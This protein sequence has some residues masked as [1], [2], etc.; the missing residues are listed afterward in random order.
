M[1]SLTGS[2]PVDHV[3]CTCLLRLLLSKL[4]RYQLLIYNFSFAW[5]TSFYHFWVQVSSFL[6]FTVGSLYIFLYVT[7]YSLHFCLYF[8]SVLKSFL[9]VSWLPV[10]WTVHLIVW[11]SI[12]LC[13]REWSEGGQCCLFGSCPSFNHLPHYPQV[14]CALFGTALVLIPGWVGLCMF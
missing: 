12:V 2:Q 3:T 14:N 6:P 7:L 8:A 9:W 4:W 11:Q 13:V 5:R 10:F 1:L